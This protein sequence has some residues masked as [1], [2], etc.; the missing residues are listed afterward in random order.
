MLRNILYLLCIA[1]ATQLQAQDTKTAVKTTENQ[2]ETAIDYKQ[3][4]APMPPLG[5][6]TFHDTTSRTELID[7]VAPPKPVEKKK[8]KK[9]AGAID[10]G[11]MKY[12]SSKELDNGY[13][14]FVMMFNPSCSHC[15]DETQMLEKNMDLFKNTKVVLLANIVQK[16][17]L[18]QFTKV[19]KIDNY[20]KMHIGVDSLGFI[21]KVFLYQ[22]L[23]QIN[24]YSGDRKLLKTFT[25]EV[26]IDSLKEYIQ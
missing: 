25:G 18:P 26:P 4:G 24:I 2:T 16:P 6:I 17:Y 14:L 13:N 9:K 11:E 19:F 22:A 21:N 23:P 7:G 8:K 3:I 1:F 5:L 10:L 15:E 12:I 20:P